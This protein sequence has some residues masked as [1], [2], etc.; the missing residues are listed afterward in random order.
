MKIIPERR[1]QADLLFPGEIQLVYSS[2]NSLL[3]R[4]MNVKSM[5][6][7]RETSVRLVFRL[8]LCFRVIKGRSNFSEY[9]KS[10]RRISSSF[11]TERA[12]VN[13]DKSS[14]EQIRSRVTRLS[15][16]TVELIYLSIWV[17]FDTNQTWKCQASS[18][19]MTMEENSLIIRLMR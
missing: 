11:V 7:S 1:C 19:M 10:R 13:K 12:H 14:N 15:L 16:W 4:H 18:T 5:I 9:P 8:P 6:C 17:F 2:S 3:I